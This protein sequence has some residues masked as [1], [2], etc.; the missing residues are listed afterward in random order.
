MIIIN[1]LSS[2]CR[3]MGHKLPLNKPYIVHLRELNLSLLIMF[4][5]NLTKALGLFK[6]V[7]KFIE[8]MVIEWFS[9]FNWN[10]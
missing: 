6:I 10:Q 2:V 8:D 7:K 3:S 4:N 9:E 5:Y 1:E